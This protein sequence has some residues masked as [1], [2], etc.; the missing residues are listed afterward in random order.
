RNLAPGLFT[1][2]LP[3]T[4]ASLLIL[5][6]RAAR[7]GIASHWHTGAVVGGVVVVVVVVVE[8]GD[9][10]SRA[11]WPAR[12]GDFGI[13]VEHAEAGVAWISLRNRSRL[14]AIRLEMWHALPGVVRVLDADAEVRVLVLRGAGEEAFA[15]GADISEFAT[16]RGDAASAA[17]YEAVT[18]GAFEARP[19]GAKPPVGMIHAGCSRGGPA[20]AAPA[21]PRAAAAR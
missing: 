4:V 21:R 20:A 11:I 1:P 10:A 14:N 7:N 6:S 16:R 18:A 12:I 3:P 15:S 13:D 19:A 8:G 17:S 9:A 2:T 5:P